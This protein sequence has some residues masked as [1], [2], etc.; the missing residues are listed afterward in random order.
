VLAALPLQ[1]ERPGAGVLAA[2]VEAD[3]PAGGGGA[4]GQ[5]GGQHGGADLVGFG[6]AGP[7]HRVEADARAAVVGE[8]VA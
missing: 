7:L 4:F 1:H 5:V 3:A 8:A 6:A 2:L